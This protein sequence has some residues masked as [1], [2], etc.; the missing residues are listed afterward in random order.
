MQCTKVFEEGI[1]AIGTDSVASNNSLNFIEEMK[2]LFGLAFI[3]ER[4]KDPRLTTPR[5]TLYAGTRGQEL[6][7]RGR[8]K[9]RGY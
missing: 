3:K 6:S 2:N 7:A 1:M 4:F 8:E 5:Q 9:T